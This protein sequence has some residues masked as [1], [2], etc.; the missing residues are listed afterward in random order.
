MFVLL[1]A[2]HRDPAWGPDADDFNPDRFLP[3]NQRALG[4]RIYKP[5]GTGPRACIGR[6]FA[7]HE[8]VLTLAAVLHQFH[9]ESDPGYQLRI[10]ETITYKPAGLKLRL[11]PRR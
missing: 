9:I 8:A 11:R 7:L 2:A 10:T 6:Q 3:D 4:P 1:D 5:F